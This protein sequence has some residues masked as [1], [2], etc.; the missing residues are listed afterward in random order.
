MFANSL[1]SSCLFRRSLLVESKMSRYVGLEFSHLYW[2]ANIA[3]DNDALIIKKP[4]FNFHH[5]GVHESRRFDYAP[6]Q[7]AQDFDIHFRAHVNFLKYTNFL[8]SF[9]LPLKLRIKIY[10]LSLDVNINQIIFHKITQKYQ[11]K[12]MKYAIPAMV[13][14]FYFSPVFW[15]L[16]LPLLIMPSFIAKKFEP[17]RWKYLDARSNMVL[18]LKRIGGLN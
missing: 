15:L 13:K 16:H 1:I 11:I 18:L 3:K 5:P 6:G 8:S 12:A 2:A 4:L 10:R 14:K 9:K 17:Y 7:P